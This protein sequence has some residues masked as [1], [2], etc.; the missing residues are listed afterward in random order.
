MA[1][2]LYASGADLTAAIGRMDDLS[3]QIRSVMARVSSAAGEAQASWHGQANMAFTQSIADWHQ[4]TTQ[5][6][7]ALVNIHDSVHS[8]NIAM[9]Q[10]ED[11]NANALRHAGGGLLNFGIG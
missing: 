3:G 6:D 9:T 7:R 8:S 2:N 4:A 5:L 10:A 11:N 1:E